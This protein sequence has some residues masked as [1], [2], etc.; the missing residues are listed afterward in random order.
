MGNHLS[1]TEITS[2][3]QAAL[4]SRLRNGHESTKPCSQPGFT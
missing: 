4:K 1:R 3:S 2:Q